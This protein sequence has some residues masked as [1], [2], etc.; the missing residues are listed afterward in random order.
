MILSFNLSLN[1]KNYR[2]EE[3]SLKKNLMKKDAQ[4]SILKKKQRN[5]L[6]NELRV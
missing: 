1:G 5:S 6:L 4:Y 2:K 3:L